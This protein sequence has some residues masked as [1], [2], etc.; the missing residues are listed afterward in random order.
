MPWDTLAEWNTAHESGQDFTELAFLEMYHAAYTERWLAVDELPALA[1][2][3][4]AVANDA[5]NWWKLLQ[6]RVWE[7]AKYYVKHTGD[8]GVESADYDRQTVIQAWG[9]VPVYPGGSGVFS[10]GSPPGKTFPAPNGFT[11]KFPREIYAL[12]NPGEEG[13]VARFTARI[14]TRW[15]GHSAGPAFDTT[16]TTPEAERVHSGKLFRH[17]GTE[18]L[19][20]S[21]AIGAGPDELSDFGLMRS[22]DYMGEWILNEIRDAINLLVWTVGVSGD[23]NGSQGERRLVGGLE[24]FATF[25]SRTTPTGSGAPDSDPGYLNQNMNDGTWIIQ[26]VFVSPEAYSRV[27]VN[28]IV[29]TSHARGFVRAQSIPVADGMRRD[30]VALIYGGAPETFLINQ[31]IFTWQWATHGDNILEGQWLQIGEEPD[32]GTFYASPEQPA[33]FTTE[34]ANLG[35]PDGVNVVYGYGWTGAAM[36]AKWHFEWIDDGD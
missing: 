8:D 21:A 36:I 4:P 24:P 16:V 3:A 27:S 28:S 9:V 20:H 13:Q 18:W 25:S 33:D 7:L 10:E 26:N 5:T 31:D 12:S 30:I 23:S 35:F 2:V 1:L 29:S 19:P 11:R 34:P 32:A 6:S 15:F 22:G 17:N 14:D